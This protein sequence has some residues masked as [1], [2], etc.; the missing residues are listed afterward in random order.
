[1][2]AIP[3]ILIAAPASG[4]GKTAAAA[5]LM[6]A[7][8]DRGMKIRACKCGP[9]Y[10]DPMFHKNVLGVESENLDLFFS[11][12]DEMKIN[13]IHHAENADLTVTEGVM[14]YY[15]GMALDTDR[16][17]SWDVAACLHM[18]VILIIP[19][20]GTALTA[21]AM[22]RGLAEFRNN[23]NIRGILLNRISG[24]LYPR[25]KQMIEKE[26]NQM[27]CRIPVV[28]YLPEDPVF[29]L[30]SRHLGLIM[31]EEIQGLQ[32]RI[33]RAGEIVSGTV[34]LDLL[35]QIAEKA[36]DIEINTADRLRMAS[37]KKIKIAVARDRA[38]CFYYRDNLDMLA[39]LGC[40]IVPFSPLNDTSLPSDINGLI[41]GGG[42]PELYAQR[43]ADNKTM[44]ASVYNA[45]SDGMPC[46][47]EC[48]GFMYLH[49]EME[50]NDKNI[51]HMAGVIKGRTFPKGKL[52]RFGY[53]TVENRY[54]TS[55]YLQEGEN[56]RGHEFHYWDSTDSG[57]DCL[58]V[59][60]GG[61]RNWECIHSAGNLF[62]GYPH[63]YLPSNKNFAIRFVRRC[64]EWRK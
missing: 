51:Y 17:S 39:R 18:P 23:S 28:G 27:G 33:R 15:D 45:I 9:D 31:P 38:F 46:L 30:E 6:A 43:L 4:S 26:L 29:H 50:D 49:E 36:P 11:S 37:D 44:L 12:R 21:A 62:A 48:G 64:R 10:I 60:P 8:R 52:V 32:D 58:A 3:R 47:A 57:T 19:A 20:R 16:G 35:F 34:D 14:G 22:I 13:F 5:S 55:G 2:T 7:Y 59:K 25:M 41:L 53:I 61:Q 56:I 24:M 54:G 40:E 1:M 63:L 42:Y